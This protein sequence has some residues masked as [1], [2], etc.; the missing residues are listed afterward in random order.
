MAVSFT[1]EC[2]QVWTRLSPLLYSASHRKPETTLTLNALLTDPPWWLCSPNKCI[3]LLV[4]PLLRGD[5]QQCCN[6]PHLLVLAS[7]MLK[8]ITQRK[9][10]AKNKFPKS[11]SLWNQGPFSKPRYECVTSSSWLRPTCPSLHA[12]PFPSPESA[13]TQVFLIQDMDI[14]FSF[15]HFI[16]PPYGARELSGCD[17]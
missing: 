6:W 14:Q 4:N 7:V 15:H 10:I 12:C 2:Q 3:V 8:L 9:E 13:V 1:R 17:F 5:P 11:G 16:L